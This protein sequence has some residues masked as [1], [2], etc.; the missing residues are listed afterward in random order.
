MSKPGPASTN[1]QSS[2][3]RESPE[4]FRPALSNNDINYVNF[5]RRLHERNIYEEQSTGT[6]HDPRR[7]WKRLL[8]SGFCAKFHRRTNKAKCGRRSCETKFARPACE[9]GRIHFCFHAFAFK[10]S[11]ETRSAR[12][13]S[14]Q[15]RF[16]LCFA[17]FAC[18]VPCGPL[19]REG[20]QSIEIAVMRARNWTSIL[21]AALPLARSNMRVDRT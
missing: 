2:V 16:Y 5:R 8:P 14:E 21:P 15:D 10:R 18:K 7:I 6:S 17:A 19:R 3:S 9:Q 4:R 12:R 11:C 20:N 1:L 13:A